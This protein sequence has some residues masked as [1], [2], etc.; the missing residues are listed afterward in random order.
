MVQGLRGPCGSFPTI[1]ALLFDRRICSSLN[2]A[3]QHQNNVK[4]YPFLFFFLVVLFGMPGVFPEPQHS[5]GDRFS[6]LRLLWRC[7]LYERLTVFIWVLDGVSYWN[8]LCDVFWGFI[9]CSRALVDFCEGLCLVLFVFPT[10]TS[11]K[12]RLIIHRA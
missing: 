9:G 11:S 7:E 1:E 6:M 10:L 8:C 12:P 3:L 4:P 2:L 5:G